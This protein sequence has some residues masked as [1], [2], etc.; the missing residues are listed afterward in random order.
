M[1]NSN[2]PYLYGGAQRSSSSH[3]FSEY[4][5]PTTIVVI[6]AALRLVQAEF[7]FDMAAIA[8]FGIAAGM[9]YLGKK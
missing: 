7:S 8:C 6:V 9:V 1:P 5:I 3:S 4:A 2:S